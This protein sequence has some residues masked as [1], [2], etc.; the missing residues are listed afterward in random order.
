MLGVCIKHGKKHYFFWNSD[1]SNIIIIYSK[2]RK[3][4][5]PKIQPKIPEG[6]RSITTNFR[7]D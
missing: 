3:V 1:S 5:R 7:A 2:K 4:G 6:I